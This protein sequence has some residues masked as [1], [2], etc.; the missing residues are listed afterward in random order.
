MGLSGILDIAKTALLTSQKA[1]QTTSHNIA[2]ANTPGYT[3]QK[4]IISSGE[5][6][7]SGGYHVGTGVTVDGIERAY[8]R[9][10]GLQ[11]LDSTG[12]KGRYEGLEE[13]LSRLE[14]IFNDLEGAGLGDTLNDL[15]DALN[16]V[17][18]DP[19]SYSARTALLGKARVLVGRIKTLNSRLEEETRNI[20]KEIKGEIEEINSL[21]ERIAAL[22]E[23]I[24]RLEAGGGKAN[25]LRD[26]RDLL[27]KE[28]AGKI[29]LTYL[30]DENGFV[31]ILVAGGHSL[32]AGGSY[33]SMGVVRNSDNHNYYDIT[34][35]NRDI[36]EWIRSGRLKGLMEARDTYYQD[37]KDKLDLFAATLIQ[38]FNYIHTQGYG[39]D[40]STG[41]NLFSDLSVTTTALTTNTGGASV[42]S[43]SVTTYDPSI[44]TLD[45]YEIRFT[46]PSEF[47]I[48][49]ITDG[50]VVS[51]GNAYVSGANIDFDG[52]RVVISDVSGSP[53][54]GDVFRISA[55]EDA[56]ED[57]SLSL[58]DPNK[59]AAAKDPST[60]PGDNENVLDMIGLKDT[61]VLSDGSA[62]FNSFYAGLVSDIGT[63]Y[64]E[65]ST[66]QEVQT[67]LTEELETYRESISGVS[68]DEEATNLVKYQHAYQAAAKV[69]RV[70][71]EMFETL[72]S[73]R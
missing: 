62:T 19:S 69:L 9:F 48:V 21:A 18:N 56:A 6:V 4:V 66:N 40:G 27:V 37:V 44:L 59:F 2:N 55:K 67:A 36:T 43:A 25:D 32:V 28:L 10:L 60:L 26:K 49:N 12:S 16:D 31:T 61:M 13:A 54:A 23:K 65:A 71:D 3:R 30:E 46:S 41:N 63:A 22:N 35:G 53:A 45:D 68:L 39:L 72:V 33:S 38:R 57:I 14:G 24:Q 42:T 58:Q 17:A 73:L 29:D 8:D 20:D 70:A 50:T 64:K 52:L 15:F 5:P 51:T 34:I 11:I 1:I 7:L 47:N